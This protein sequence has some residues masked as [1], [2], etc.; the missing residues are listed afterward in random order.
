MRAFAEA[1]C[2]KESI[3]VKPVYSRQFPGHG[4]DPRQLLAERHLTRKIFGDLQFGALNTAN[5]ELGNN[6]VQGVELK[7][8]TSCFS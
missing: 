3:A 1:I 2:V 6:V 7:S 5:R 8:E 4:P